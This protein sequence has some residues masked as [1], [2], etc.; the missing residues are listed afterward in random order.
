MGARTFSTIRSNIMDKLGQE[1]TRTQTAVGRFINEAY[2]DVL[3]FD[4]WTWARTAEPM[5]IYAPVTRTQ[6]A[7]DLAVSGTGNVT[8]TAASFDFA[9]QGVGAGWVVVDDER[10]P[11]SSVA[12]KVITLEHGWPDTNDLTSYNIYGTWYPLSFTGAERIVNKVFA[13]SVMDGTERVDL[14]PVSATC[15]LDNYY[16]ILTTGVPSHFSIFRWTD[17]GIPCIG[18]FPIPDADYMATIHY[19]RA[20]SEL[21]AST[22]ETLYMP[23]KWKHVVEELALAKVFDAYIRD[24]VNANRLF[25]L[26][27]RHMK[28]M[29]RENQSHSNLPIRPMM[30]PNRFERVID[31]YGKFV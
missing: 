24:P 18:F 21:V 27:Q 8:L 10:R 28:D 30:G 26:A 11:V 16:D 19:Y 13:V 14:I 22:A 23:E 7:E 5:Q 2:S 31:P 15:F 12:T 29:V 20:P 9:A 3:A 4:E 6:T 17:A 1:D 25:A